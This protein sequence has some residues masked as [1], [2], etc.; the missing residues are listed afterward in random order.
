[1][2]VEVKEMMSVW[3]QTTLS[4]EAPGPDRTVRGQQLQ[5]ELA[6]QP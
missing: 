5:D 6:L 1:M 4:A 2:M 3:S